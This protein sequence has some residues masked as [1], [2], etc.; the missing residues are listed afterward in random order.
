MWEKLMK[1]AVLEE[2]YG[3]SCQEAYHSVDE[4]ILSWIWLGDWRVVTV[5]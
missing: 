1:P 2:D 3:L 5:N 4:K